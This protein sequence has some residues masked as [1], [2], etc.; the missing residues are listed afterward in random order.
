MSFKIGSRTNDAKLEHFFKFDDVI[1]ANL[2][3]S[4]VRLGLS[5]VIAAVILT[6]FSALLTFFSPTCYLNYHYYTH[7]G[8]VSLCISQ[9][10]C[11]P[12]D[13]DRRKAHLIFLQNGLQTYPRLLS[14]FFSFFCLGLS[15]S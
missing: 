2:E 14:F 9:E 4:S 13:L 6:C 15:C 3:Y 8:F 12:V 1:Q 11:H 10:L 5:I 7:V